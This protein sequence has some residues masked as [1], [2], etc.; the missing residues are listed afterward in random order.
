MNIST[1]YRMTISFKLRLVQ[2][3]DKYSIVSSLENNTLGLIG[4]KG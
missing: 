3:F 1:E 4:P 2:A